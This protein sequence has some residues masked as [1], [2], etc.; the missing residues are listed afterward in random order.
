MPPSLLL[1]R[2]LLFLV[3]V[4]AQLGQAQTISGTITDAKSQVGVPFVNIGVLGKT[5]GTVANEQGAYQLAVAGASPNDTVRI[6]SVGF[7]PRNLTV[8][9]LTSQPNLALRPEAIALG[10]VKVRAKTLFKRT[11]TLGNTTNSETSTLTLS[12]K[13]LG[14]EIGTVISLK[15]KPTKVLNANFNVAYNRAGSLTFR[16]NLYRLLPNGKPSDVK[17]V[18]RNIIVTSAVA[19]GPIA[20]DLTADQLILDEDFFLTLEWIGGGDA[21]QVSNQLAFSAGLGYANNDLYLRETSQA[22][23][24][25]ASAGAVLAGMQPK[26]SFYVTVQD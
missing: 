11:H 18:T 16:V 26:I 19:K 2:S 22:A 23:W 7:K 14:S 1:K 5:V 21:K 24:E 25:R 4:T 17:L 13:D 6:S 3:L 20:V 12:A 8:R 15:R 10:E 9:E